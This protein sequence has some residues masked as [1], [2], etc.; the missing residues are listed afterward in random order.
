MNKYIFQFDINNYGWAVLTRSAARPV[1]LYI[2]EIVTEFI[3][4]IDGFKAQ[5]CSY[6]NCY[7]AIAQLQDK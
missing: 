4:V 1:C 6:F 2:Y 3:V 5:S 7:Q